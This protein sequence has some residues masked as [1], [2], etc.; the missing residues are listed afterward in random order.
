MAD[1]SPVAA[2]APPP[3]AAEPLR[4]VLF[5]LPAAG[6]TSL[7]GALAQAAR[8]QEHLLHG[9][10]VDH[11]NGLDKLRERLYQGNPERTAE[12][13]APYAVDFEPFAEDG[14]APQETMHAEMIDC[15]GRAVDDLL[16]QE[17]NANENGTEGT[18]VRAIFDA[19][20]LILVVDASAAEGQVDN[21]F[22][23]FDRFLNKMEHSRGNRA[24]VG[25]LPV[26]L[27]LTKCDLLAKPTDT[28]ADWMEHI[29]QRKRDVD[30]RF[31]DLLAH[32]QAGFGRIDLRIWATAIKRPALLGAPAKPNEPY[33]VAELFRECLEQAADFR[34]REKRSQHRLVVTVSIGAAVVTL[35]LGLILGLL[36][37]NRLP[38]ELQQ[39]VENFRASDAGTVDYRLRGPASELRHR[40]SVVQRF[41]T[42]PNFG[43]LPA[44]DRDWVEGRIRELE[45]YIPYLEAV[46]KTT[47][48]VDAGSIETLRDIKRHLLDLQDRFHPLDEWGPSEA[49]QTVDRYT[50]DVGALEKGQEFVAQW[51]FKRRAD[52]LDLLEFNGYLPGP[53][54]AS[55]RWRPWSDEAARLLKKADGKDESDFDYTAK[56]PDA[57][58]PLT[59]L[60]VADYRA[61]RVA[62]DQWSRARQQLERLR[63]VAAALG[64]IDGGEQRPPV[65]KL[66]ERLTLART[67]DRARDLEKFYPRFK[68]EFAVAAELPEPVRGQLIGEARTNYGYL[69]GPKDDFERGPVREYI[70]A[71]FFGD[72]G[73]TPARWAAV[74]EW[75][76]DP[77]ELRDW[78]IVAGAL[79][80]LQDPRPA[81]AVEALTE[82][83]DKREFTIDLRTLELEIPTVLG[84]RP[85]PGAS[86]EVFWVRSPASI[87]LKMND[88][89]RRDRDRDAFRCTFE[90]SDGKTVTY[91]PGDDFWATLELPNG[92][93]FTW[94]KCRSQRW[95]FE[96]LARPPWLHE[97]SK[98]PSKGSLEKK[99]QLR[100]IKG[101]LPALP[102]LLPAVP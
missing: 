80:Q 79:G 88:D 46:E 75:L 39:R 1:P 47:P 44:D 33:G 15:D 63:D 49:S 38:G 82:F 51:Y 95:Q 70:I 73:E 2:A 96:C 99:V 101:S 35:M 58:S 18:L 31:R 91:K 65:L 13:T 102:D 81:D 77:R 14:A 55:V 66:S 22:A 21:D 98:S 24:E 27:V 3:A 56:V 40:L 92:M 9:H 83:L 12:E 87:V 19:D 100:V 26:F 54:S 60:A 72:G 32:R 20:A 5:G 6:K 68:D 90:V 93:R 10:L 62:R 85:R 78:R 8:T 69:L 28:F 42:D 23:E 41:R 57:G 16:K 4:L 50:K 76:K 29:E 11:S 17:N 30:G 61:V 94:M 48:P 86:L 89:P 59:Y 34:R 52:V 71:R 36:I 97:V 43:A 7:L 53:E 84:T 64:L 25:G 37:S 67:S 74:R 45:A